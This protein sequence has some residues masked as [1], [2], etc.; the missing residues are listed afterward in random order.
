MANSDAPF[1]F[2]PVMHRGGAPFN[3]AANLYLA[4]CGTSLFIGDPVLITGQSNSTELNGMPPGSVPI[5]NVVGTTDTSAVSGV[6]VGVVPTDATSTIYYAGTKTATQVW[7]ADDPDLLFEVQCDGTITQEEVGKAAVMVTTHAGSTT[8]GRSGSEISAT[9]ATQ[10]VYVLERLVPK[11]D[12]DLASANSKLIVS[13][14]KHTRSHSGGR[15]V[16]NLGLGIA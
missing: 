6:I 3:G 15:G 16:A 2:R 13:V 12:N 4:T 14:R 9:L 10:G 1:G 5:V 11:A 8:T 7:V